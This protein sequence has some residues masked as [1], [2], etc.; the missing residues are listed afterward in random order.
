MLRIAL[1]IAR[2]NLREEIVHDGRKELVAHGT[3]IHV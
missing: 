3:A 1:K 2:G